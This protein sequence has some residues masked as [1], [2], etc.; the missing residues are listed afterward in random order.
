MKIPFLSVCALV[1]SGCATDPA[2][3]EQLRLTEQAIVQARAV[4]ATEQVPALRQAEDKL[5][6][7]TAAMKDRDYRRARLQAEQAELD[8]RYAEAQVLN[9]K[10]E[11]QLN[12]LNRRIARLREQLGALR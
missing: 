2:P 1:L 8:A 4:G 11:L 3:S 12:E 6:N 9:D 10:S 5:A 7:A